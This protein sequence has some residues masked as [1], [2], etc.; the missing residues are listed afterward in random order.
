MAHS[1]E[2]AQPEEIAQLEHELAA[3]RSQYA[4]LERTAA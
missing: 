3:L 2:S 4:L 1:E